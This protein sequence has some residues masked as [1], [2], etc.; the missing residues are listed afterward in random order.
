MR[1]NKRAQDFIRRFE[2]HG[3]MAVEH[4]QY[5]EMRGPNGKIH[6]ISNTIG[7]NDPHGERQALAALMRLEDAQKQQPATIAAGMPKAY[8]PPT[9]P[10]GAGPSASGA[11]ATVRPW[12]AR[13][14]SRSDGGITYESGA[15]LER[16]SSTGVVDYLCAAR[17][18]FASDK[19][20]SVAAHYGKAH[21]AKGE[22]AAE[23]GATGIDPA[24][25]EPLTHRAYRPSQRLIQTLAEHLRGLDIGA[26]TDE[27]L[28][29]EFLTWA[30][31]RPDLPEP[32][33]RE[34]LDA[35]AILERVRRLV[36]SPQIS[37]CHRALDEA[38]QRA[39][40]AE[41]NL[42]A[43]RD[44]LDEVAPKHNTGN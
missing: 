1:R 9:A 33:P 29:E 8:E 15:V 32:E 42:S 19:P 31:D 37:E 6:R 30:H 44:L 39:E 12:M 7:S 43:M 11:S 25:T 18:G 20:R 2:S 23:P 27:E 36:W 40:R 28:A 34:P 38:T 14:A 3:Y 16:T 41:S 17:C 22:Q 24:Y 21:T 4:D 26:L 13:K 5:V 35:E 10:V